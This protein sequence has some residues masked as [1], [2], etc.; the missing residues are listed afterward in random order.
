MMSRRRAVITGGAGFLGSHLCDRLL[1]DDYEVLCLDNFLTGTRGNLESLV[2]TERLHVECTD[3]TS[4]INVSGNVDIVLNFASS[5]SPT[6]YLRFP[7]DTLK[8]GAFGTWHTLELARKKSARYILAST[9]EVYGDPLV[10]PQPESYWG[11]VNPIGPRSVY[12]EAKRFAEALVTAYR[13]THRVETSII[14][15]FNTYGPRMR[16]NDGRA[17]PTFIRQALLGDPLT[18]TGDGSQ[19]RSVC[20]VDDLIDGISRLIGT[21]VAGPIN[22]GNPHEIS[23]LKLAQLIR[24]LTGSKSPIKLVDRPIDDPQV[25]QPD[26]SQ[27][28]SVLGG[29]APVVPLEDG[30]RRTIHGFRE[31]LQ[32]RVEARYD[33]A[34]ALPTPY[35]A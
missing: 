3:I 17:I 23:M 21:S 5:A 15:I 9:S 4:D 27:A 33:Q 1:L 31:V 24:T 26:I 20:Y 10:H 18:V 28:R 32:S 19:T 2:R 7:I 25:R 29:W 16:V 8:V 11:N 13:N 12:D 22:L 14:R 6:D 34:G 30:L 35:T